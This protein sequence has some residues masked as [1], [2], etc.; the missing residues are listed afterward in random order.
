[1]KT[2]SNKVFAIAVALAALGLSLS[3]IQQANGASFVEVSP[4]NVKRAYHTATLLPNGKV[5]VTGTRVQGLT[6]TAKSAELYDPA[7]DSW[8]LT[9]SMR[10]FC[11][12]GY[13]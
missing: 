4:M 10:S 11:G 6:D 7:T 2:Q 5:L 1:M 3:P 12:Y 9:G 13:H 8:T